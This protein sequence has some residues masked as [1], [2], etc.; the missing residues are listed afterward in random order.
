MSC[1]FSYKRTRL[2]AAILMLGMLGSVSAA[3]AQRRRV[4]IPAARET[5]SEVLRIL[6]TLEQTGDFPQAMEATQVLFDQV[7][8]HASERE[9][10]RFLEA[11]FGHRLVHQLAVVDD[12]IRLDLLKYLRS[13]ENL[14]YNMA[15]T[16]RPEQENVK[17]VY[18][19]LQRFQERR[20]EDLN[21]YA[22]LT[23]AI[24]VVHDQPLHRGQ[25]GDVPPPAGPQALFDFFSANEGRLL[26]PIRNMPPEL[27]IY[28]VNSN[29]SI[30]EMLW[31]L[32]RFQGTNRVGELFYEVTYDADALEE[33][34]PQASE[35]AG[36]TLPNIL[37]FGGGFNESSFFAEMVGKSIGTPTTTVTGQ[38]LEGSYSWVGF[39]QIDHR[40]GA[41][42]NME[43]GRF[44]VMSG[45]IWT[46]GEVLDPQTNKKIS[47]N[48]LSLTAAL[49][50]RPFAEKQAAA[51]LTDA[52][53]RLMML[54]ESGE[55][56]EPPTL[57]AGRGRRTTGRRREANID[58]Q[59]GLLERALRISPG[60]IPAWYTLRDLAAAGKLN[61]Q[62]KESWINRLYRIVGNEFPD[63]TLNIL[64]PM[65]ETVEDPQ[66]QN[67]LWE[68]AF[69]SFRGHPEL[70]A[71]VRMGQADLWEKNDEPA[72]ALDFYREIVRRYAN[73]GPFILDALERAERLLIREHQPES[74][75]AQLYLNAWNRIDRPARQAFQLHEQTT[76]YRV[77]EK[78]AQKLVEAGMT[79]QAVAVQN[80]ISQP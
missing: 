62:E 16:V 59:L 74:T 32:N 72:R 68:I 27:L 61:W 28:M 41:V 49:F 55:D 45:G 8:R 67:S 46:R 73:D 25:G 58:A 19:L 35:L 23:T 57:E 53:Q 71:R 36:Q 10:G 37:R 24:C 22:S 31:G 54:E 12:D 6:D 56:F 14:A 15:F 33:G 38:T 5:K 63:F 13:N 40:R 21:R 77:G 30:Q 70:A 75:V 2:T 48:E 1:V 43:E 39:L 17:D 65:I 9:A 3:H 60:Y 50:G 79:Q 66:R 52:V 78:L 69:R 44:N 26:F 47:E 34:G 18:D 76:W 80:R 51:A 64:L 20:G 4:R 29:V 7:I 42:W 11:A